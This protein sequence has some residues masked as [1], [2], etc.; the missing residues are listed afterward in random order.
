MI[1]NI[2][3]GNS[4]Y[5]EDFLANTG[6]DMAVVVRLKASAIDI[7]LLLKRNSSGS[8]DASCRL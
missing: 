7:E 2:L 5:K 1:Y 3:R 4:I 8:E 6:M